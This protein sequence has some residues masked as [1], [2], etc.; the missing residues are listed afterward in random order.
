MRSVNNNNNSNNN[1]N[2][3]NNSSV[4]T[5]NAAATA[6]VSA[7]SRVQPTTV[8]KRRWGGC[9]SLYWC[10]GSHKTKRIGHAVLAPEPEVQGAVVTSAENQSQSTAITV[11]FIA[12]PS[13]PASFL[14]SDPPS[15][16]QSPAGLLSL[17]SLSVN[18]YS[19][20]GPASIFAIGPYAHETQLVTPPAFSAFTTEPSTAPFTPPPESVQLTTPS[21]PEVPFAQLLTSSLERARRN[22]GTNQKFALSH[23]EFQSYPLYPGSPGGQ[24]ISPGSVISNSGTSSPFPDRY[25]ILEFRMG[26]APKLLGFEHFTTRKWGSRLGSGTVTPDGVGLGSR[27]GSGTVTPDG[28]GQGS[29]LGSGTVT[30][31]GVGLRSMLGSGSLTPDAVGPAS[32]DGFFLENQIS[33]VA[34]LANSENGSKTD[35]NIVDHRVSFEL[36]GEE[37]ARCLESKSLA[38]C[39]AFSECPPDSMAED[40][41][42]SGKM[43]M[44]DENLP[45][46]ETSGETPEKPSGEMEEEHCY[47]KHRSITLGSIKEFNFDNS[48]EVPDKPSINSEWWA[49]ETIAG[50]EARPANNWTFFPLLQPEVS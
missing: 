17:T 19:P 9:W 48:K 25:P 33:E 36:S 13:S 18:A 37:V 28:V 45:T 27:L 29:R 15:A 12:P 38:S 2:N 46:G 39:R 10:F 24:L 1:S 23:Y 35:E 34:S 31:D 41:I 30:P 32:R 49:N 7:E 26:E 47:R 14:Q 8:Q 42:K 43:L 40:Q 5:I 44:T 22:S 3:N 6:I 16:T 50:K 11:P 21:S 4:D 20:G